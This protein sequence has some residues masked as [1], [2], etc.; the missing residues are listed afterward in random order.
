MHGHVTPLTSQLAVKVLMEMEPHMI[1]PP[2]T[3][4]HQLN[5]HEFEQPPGDSDEQGSMACFSPWGR[6]E[7][8]KT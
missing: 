4:Q 8:D 6:K 3:R 7:S 1:F 2:L 5:G